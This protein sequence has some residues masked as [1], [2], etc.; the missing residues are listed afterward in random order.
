MS[1]Q[2]LSSVITADI[3]RHYSFIY[4][5]CTVLQIAADIPRHYSFIYVRCTV[6]QITADIQRHLQFCTLQVYS[7]SVNHVIVTTGDEV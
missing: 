4:V 5:R 6:L 2:V 7:T 1:L 3:P